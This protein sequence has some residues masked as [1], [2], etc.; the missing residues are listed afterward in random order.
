M[1]SQEN[2][3][4]GGYEKE[5][6]LLKRGGR[7]L[8]FTS[9]YFLLQGPKLIYK[10]NQNSVNIRGEFDLAPGCIVT[11]IQ[12]DYIGTIKGKKVFS[13]WLVWP[14]DKRT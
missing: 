2:N 5:G 8:R 14:H 10:L 12:E 1:K 11:E 3:H 6:K 13:F 7:M 9:R 4:L